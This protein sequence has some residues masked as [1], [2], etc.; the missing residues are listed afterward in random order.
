MNLWSYTIDHRRD[1]SRLPLHRL[2]I[3]TSH[4]SL[5]A[6]SCGHLQVDDRIEQL[7]L[8]SRLMST[9]QP[10]QRRHHKKTL[11]RRITRLVRQPVPTERVHTQCSA[12]ANAPH[13]G[14]AEAGVGFQVP[15]EAEGVGGGGGESGRGRGG[16]GGGGGGCSGSGS[17]GEVSFGRV[18]SGLWHGRTRGGGGTKERSDVDTLVD[19][20]GGCREKWRE[21]EARVEWTSDWRR[22]E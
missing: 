21:Y 18:G 9:P 19:G 20:S 2:T 13:E 8:P 16:G 7:L 17:G 1:C 12:E 4:P 10:R 6:L 14:G 22:G 11:H 5:P 15:D 3:A